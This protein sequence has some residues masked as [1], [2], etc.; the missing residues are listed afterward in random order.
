MKISVKRKSGFTGLNSF[1]N[2][3]TKTAVNSMNILLIGSGGREH[4]FAAKITESPKC[5]KLYVAPGNAGTSAIAEKVDLKVTDF[6]G[7]KDFVLS[8]HIDMVVVGPGEPLVNALSDFFANEPSTKDIIVVGP[9]KQ[10]AALE[11]SKDVS[12]EFMVRNSIPTA[13]YHSFTKDT[14]DEGLP[15]I[16]RQRL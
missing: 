9:S 1:Q 16:R 11:G 13:A 4:A 6:E 7:I 2:T 10:G 15:F 12:K 5:K 3:P 8:R 14:V